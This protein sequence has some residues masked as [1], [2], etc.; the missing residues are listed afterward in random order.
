MIAR[1]VAHVA[2]CVEACHRPDWTVVQL[3]HR[4]VAG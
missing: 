4:F 2:L 3:Q 1:R